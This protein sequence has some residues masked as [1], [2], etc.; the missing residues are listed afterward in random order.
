MQ[1]FTVWSFLRVFLAVIVFG[2]LAVASLDVYRVV[3]FDAAA[4]RALELYS[5]LAVTSGWAIIGLWFFA[6]ARLNRGLEVLTA[7]EKWL[8]LLLCLVAAYARFQA[9]Q[10]AAV[11]MDPQYLDGPDSGSYFRTAAAAAKN[12]DAVYEN[13]FWQ[14]PGYPLFLAGLFRIF[15]TALKVAWGAQIAFGVLSVWLT[16]IIAR[17]LLGRAAGTLAAFL[18]AGSGYFIAYGS[19]IGTEGLGIVLMQ[20]T[21]LSLLGERP[22][23]GSRG[24]AAGCLFGGLAFVRVGYIPF[25]PVFLL[26]LMLSRTIRLKGAALFVAGFIVVL[27]PWTIRNHSVMGEW[28]PFHLPTDH[29]LFLSRH[30]KLA[31]MKVDLHD[32]K[33]LA[34]A[35]VRDPVGFSAAIAAPPGALERIRKY[36]DYRPH[37]Y[38]DLIHLVEDSYFNHALLLLEYGLFVLGAVIAL[39]KAPAVALLFLLLI[40]YRS[41][42]GAWTYYQHWH[43][44]HIEFMVVLFHAASLAWLARGLRKPRRHRPQGGQE[45]VAIDGDSKSFHT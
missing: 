43:R 8:I 35:F 40:G 36:W 38:N 11:N 31:A 4:I 16:W 17:R 32:P 18:Q 7:N 19:Y 9:V 44:F 34:S 25:L 14:K 26:W 42:F 28:T 41:L 37:R 21:V 15:G 5:L 10:H 1:Q 3:F 33:T 20:L 45:V 30:P 29:R 27:T 24:L 23:S 39:R 22:I 12:F 2:I 6:P 13:L